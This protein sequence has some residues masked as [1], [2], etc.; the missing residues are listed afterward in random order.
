MWSIWRL[1][2]NT[3][4]KCWE[5]VLYGMIRGKICFFI[6]H[7]EILLESQD[8]WLQGVKKVCMVQKKFPSDRVAFWKCSAYISASKG[9]LG[10]TTLCGARESC[11]YDVET[12]TW[13][14]SRCDLKR[15]LWM[16]YSHKMPLS[17]LKRDVSHQWH[18]HTHGKQFSDSPLVDLIDRHG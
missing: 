10:S 18:I 3:C 16:C 8:F 12:L 14:G 6:T 11:S 2:S 17:L 9:L 5:C 7:W 15:K 1:N 13:A 4:M